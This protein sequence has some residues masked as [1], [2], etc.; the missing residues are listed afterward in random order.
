MQNTFKRIIAF[1]VMVCMLFCA[2]P[3]MAFA[4]D[5]EPAQL[6]SITYDFQQSAQTYSWNEN[7]DIPLGGN[8]TLS[9]AN[10]M[11]LNGAGSTDFSN[12][13]LAARAKLAE[14]YEAGTIHWKF[15]SVTTARSEMSSAHISFS[16]GSSSAPYGFYVRARGENNTV[17][18][19]DAYFAF[20]VRSPGTG[21][22]NLTLNYRTHNTGAPKGSVY[23]LP[24][25]VT[26]IAGAMDYY[27]PVGSFNS[28]GSK[29]GEGNDSLGTV[30]MK[31]GKEYLLVFT[32]DEVNATGNSYL[33][34]TS[35]TMDIQEQT[36]VQDLDTITYE[37]DLDEKALSADNATT[38][39]GL[40]IYRTSASTNNQAARDAI[41]AYYEGGTLYWKYHSVGKRADSATNNW[42]VTFYNRSKS[43]C[44]LYLNGASKTGAF[45]AMTIKSP[46]SG[47]YAMTLDYFTHTSGASKGSVY[48]L[49][50][51]TV[52][53]A[54]ALDTAVAVGSFSC[55]GS[56]ITTPKTV[57]FDTPVAM[58]A[59]AEYLLVFTADEYNS[60]SKATLFLGNVTMNRAPE[61]QAEL[62]YNF[63][64]TGYTFDYTKSGTEYPDTSFDSVNLVNSSEK[65]VAA[66]TT[67]E[68]LYTDKVVNWKYKSATGSRVVPLV[69][70]NPGTCVEM[71]DS[72]HGTGFNFALTVRSPGPGNY[73]MDLKYV[74]SK[75][76][77]GSASVYLLP[78]GT[79]E[80]DIAGALNSDT[81]IANFTCT[82]T[83]DFTEITKSYDVSFGL[84]EEYL[85][86]FTNVEK[87]PVNTSDRATIYVR[88]ILLT[89]K[90]E[91]VGEEEETGVFVADDKA[92][93]DIKEAVRVALDGD[94]IITLKDDCQIDELNLLKDV[95][96]DLNGNTLTTDAYTGSIVDSSE[97]NQ[98]LLK[99]EANAA[100]FSED[101]AD[102][103]LYD[104]AEGGYRLFDYT[105]EL[106]PTVEPVGNAS[107]KF[108]FKF[109][110]RNGDAEGAELAQDAY[111]LVSAG[112]SNFQI[113]TELSWDGEA[114]EPVFFGINDDVDAFSKEWATGATASRWL[115]VI[116]NGLGSDMEGT[117][118]VRPVL[119][120]NGVRITSDVLSYTCQAEA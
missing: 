19:T 6:D 80:E 30:S 2:L 67:W 85:L 41:D 39:V 35:V 90:D 105:L 110:F 31:A 27:E 29:W 71:R 33:Y 22:Y 86:V 73:T 100:I 109:H 11:E 40:D 53:I 69:T 66:K 75:F 120:A 117:L 70:T 111:D 65:E 81:L 3:M 78:V 51:D 58:E 107:Q 56:K 14:L 9:A 34:L 88:N 54:T 59:G 61:S 1:A 17:H 62:E 93:A 91:T 4:E 13:A 48:V 38:F 25:S 83:S 84:D 50:G 63:D 72:T 36:P 108:W 89:N 57:T 52:D 8:D 37:F 42:N 112:G 99:V 118:T 20:T 103:P 5:T 21:D 115:Y 45:F 32:M 74:D 46:G 104:T 119:W 43:N 47:N 64:L 23:V 87:N 60:S 68:A 18:L 55:E 97:G 113:S 102:V 96:L 82:G 16:D 101:N 24:S 95:S 94:Q 49:P 12:K 15:H 79:E 7:V 44:D 28:Y 92:Y 10:L 114:L 26:D 77:A 116:V 98:G 76:S 106:H